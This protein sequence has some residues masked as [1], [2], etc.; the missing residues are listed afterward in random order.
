MNCTCQFLSRWI[1]HVFYFDIWYNICSLISVSCDHDDQTNI[2]IG[3]CCSI[4]CPL[5]HPPLLPDQYRSTS[6]QG[7]G[8]SSGYNHVY[9]SQPIPKASLGGLSLCFP[10]FWLQGQWVFVSNMERVLQLSSV[11]K[12]KPN[13]CVVV[14]VMVS[15]ETNESC[16]TPGV[17]FGCRPHF[18]WSIS[19]HRF[20]ATAMFVWDS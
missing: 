15:K 18:G 9:C 1:L 11:C 12:S 10:H 5:F 2:V 7:Q 17:H 8:R 19:S 4:D 3:S 13:L 16:Y 6:C 20:W 14:T